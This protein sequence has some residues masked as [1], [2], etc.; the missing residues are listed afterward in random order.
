MMWMI[1]NVT[2]HTYGSFEVIMKKIDFREASFPPTNKVIDDEQ[3]KLYQMGKINFQTSIIFLAP[4]VSLVLLNIASFIG[5]L[6]RAVVTEN[7]SEMFVQ[8][9]LSFFV[10]VMN[11]PIVEGMILRKD[12]GRIPPS[13]T[14]LSTLISLAF[15]SLGYLFFMYM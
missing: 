10:V 5:G 14:I 3:L 12:K 13:V 9:V 15:L 4:M 8:I 6:T 2:C 1:K 11:Y 7:F